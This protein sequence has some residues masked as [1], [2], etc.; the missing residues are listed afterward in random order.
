MD[1]AAPPSPQD[2]GVTHGLD[3]ARW[4]T[5]I[6]NLLKKADASDPTVQ[7]AFLEIAKSLERLRRYKRDLTLGTYKTYLTVNESVVTSFPTAEIVA[8]PMVRLMDAAGIWSIGVDHRIDIANVEML[9]TML[10][11]PEEERPDAASMKYITINPVKYIV[12]FAGEQVVETGVGMPTPD[13]GLAAGGSEV[14]KELFHQ[15]ADVNNALDDAFSGWGGEQSDP[16]KVASREMARKIEGVLPSLE[17]LAALDKKAPGDFLRGYFERDFSELVRGKPAEEFLTALGH[18]LRA[19]PPEVQAKIFQ[20]AFKKGERDDCVEAL[21]GTSADFRMNFLLERMKGMTAM[22]EV[23]DLATLVVAPGGEVLMVE[24]IAKKLLTPDLQQD[25]RANLQK[26][27]NVFGFDPARAVRRRIVLFIGEAGTDYDN[28]NKL[29]TKRGYG[30]FLWDGTEATAGDGGIEVQPDIAIVDAPA[31]GEAGL[32]QLKKVAAASTKTA[33]IVFSEGAVDMTPFYELGVSRTTILQKPVPSDILLSFFEDRK[34][35]TKVPAVKAP[36]QSMRD[37]TSKYMKADLARARE[38]Q[39]RLI[40]RDIP[41]VS[42]AEIAIAYRPCNEVGGDY[43]DLFWTAP[44]KLGFVIADVSGKGV[45]AAMVMVMVRSVFRSVA[46]GAGSARETMIQVNRMLARDVKKGIFV[47]ALYGIYDVDSQKVTVANGGHNP[48]VMW[49]HATGTGEYLTVSGMALGL[50]E[51]PA[52]DNSIKE[53]IYELAPGDKMLSYTDGVTE[54]F[55]ADGDMY[56]EDRLLEIFKQQG[57][58]AAQP[59]IDAVMLDIDKFVG[60]APRSDDTTML[61]IGR[62]VGSLIDAVG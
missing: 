16:L 41:Q 22:K 21:R 13:E 30:V 26:L 25:D 29:L 18:V 28:I 12:V 47:S 5:E 51:R 8:A 50:T 62:P 39:E 48:P 14:D 59:L 40:P 4:I 2:F 34:G 7:V 35:Q 44:G 32:A 43:L 45:A 55:A 27:L 6:A 15:E 11:R 49:H 61:V 24:N 1:P 9:A 23:R 17:K 3:F 57:K 53:V 60:K 33:I 56:G 58:N 46:A 42:G 19:L 54:A 10:A 52:F 31:A 38:I 37:S 36:G 20:R